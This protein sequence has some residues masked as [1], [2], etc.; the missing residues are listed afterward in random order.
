MTA[1]ALM[2]IVPLPVTV[3][4]PRIEPLPVSFPPVATLTVLP[5]AMTPS[6][7]KI[8]VITFVAPV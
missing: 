5:A 1:P 4:L 7:S 2:L 6:F 8:P 3:A